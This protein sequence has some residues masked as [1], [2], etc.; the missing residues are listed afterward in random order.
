MKTIYF[1]ASSLD[2]YIADKNHSLDWLFQFKE[3]EGYIEKFIDTVGAL[4]MGP[5]TYQWM[6][7]H[8]PNFGDG[9][10]PY[11]VPAYVFT[12]RKLPTYPNA[13]I[14]FVNG[15]VK[16]VHAQM[17]ADANGKNIWIVG[18]GEL[19]GKFYDAQLLNELI[20]QFAS[21]TLGGGSPLF[22]RQLA[23]PLKLASVQRLAEEFVEVRYEVN[24]GAKA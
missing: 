22:P 2:G 24:Y 19:V 16:S 12:S 17:T 15:D 8:L 21:V 3:P 4:A 18:G 10:W 5:T 9:V 13:N 20:I 7:D 23:T 14:R 11:K 6:L 1:T